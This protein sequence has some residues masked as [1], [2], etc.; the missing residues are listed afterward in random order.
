M[1]KLE[2]LAPAGS[3]ESMMAAVNSGA[4]AVYFGY[5][6]FNARRN[7]KNFDEN[8]FREMARYCKARGVK[9]YMTLNTLVFD[10]EMEDLK[11]SVR[12]ACENGVDAILVQDLGVMELLRQWAPEIPLHASTQ[13]AVHNVSGAKQMQELGFTRVVL[14]REMSAE[15]I[16]AVVEQVPVETE[17]FVHGA[18]CMCLSGQCYM[19]SLIGERSGNRGLCAQPCRLPFSSGRGDNGYALSLK[20]LTLVDRIEE[21]KALGVDSLKIEGRMK[22]PEYVSAAVSGFRQ[23]LNGE[24]PNMEQLEAAFSRSGFTRGYF[25][26]KLGIDMFGTRQHED[27]LAGQ[28]VLKQLSNQLEKEYPHIGVDFR[29]VMKAGQSVTLTASDPD[30]NCV[31]VTAEI[32]ESA[33]NRPTSEELVRRSMEK[34]GGTFYYLNSLTCE[35]DDGLICPASQMNQLRREALEQLSA[36]RSEIKPWTFVDTP[37]PAHPKKLSLRRPTLRAQ[38]RKVEQIT[39]KMAEQCELIAVP[40]DQLEKNFAQL[41]A[42]WAEKIAV[43]P[44]RIVFGDDAALLEERLLA[45]KA[46][47]IRHLCAGNIGMVHLARRL[48]FII[49]GDTSLNIANSLS[50]KEYAELGLADALVSFELNH[51]RIKSLGDYLPHGIFAYGRLPLM[52]T[53]NCPIKLKGCKNCQQYGVLKDRKGETFEVRCTQRQYSEIFNGKPLYLADKWNEWNS[54]DFAL[55]YFTGETAEEV[56]SVIRSYSETFE[57]RE[58]VTRGLY[59]RNVK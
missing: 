31:S 19:S 42:E 38:V 41:S 52:V 34:L 5:G 6:Q 44:P 36:L 4:D 50:M 43:V 45:L 9:M 17:I 51:G 33:M 20:D 58:G 21:L 46:K 12:A 37:I 40:L 22:R 29:F 11:E 48:G 56:D 32:P 13:M 26:G 27:V 3:M 10:R 47:G 30:G 14:A 24:E 7:A 57:K 25:D 1:S 55:L 49:H 23:A 16:R 39:E 28:K 15:E 54:F 53:R 2:I 18:L 8:Q 35:L 59:Y